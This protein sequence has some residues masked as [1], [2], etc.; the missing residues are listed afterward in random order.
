MKKAGEI[1][2]KVYQEAKEILEEGMTEIEFGGLLEGVL[3]NMAMK[4]FSGSGPLTMR[5]TRGTY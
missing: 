4:G 5:L 1:G 3:R 2:T